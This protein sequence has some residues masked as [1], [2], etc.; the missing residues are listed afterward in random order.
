M[1]TIVPDMYA[2]VGETFSPRAVLKGADGVAQDL[3]L[4]TSVKMNLRPKGGGVKVFT[5]AVC[6]FVAGV[7]GQVSFDS[8]TVLACEPGDYEMDYD[9]YFPGGIV[10]TFPNGGPEK[11]DRFLYVRISEQA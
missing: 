1:A 3:T 2:K 10:H 5:D 11:T 9:A 7:G 4:A 6:Q 8:P